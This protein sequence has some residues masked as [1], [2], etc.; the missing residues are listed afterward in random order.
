MKCQFFQSIELANCGEA[1][2]LENIIDQ[3]AFNEYGLIPVVTQDAETHQV[4]MLAYMNKDALN[5]TL[6]TKRVTYWSRSRR[7][8]WE[9]GETSGHSQNLV[10]M[11]FDCDGDAILCKVNQ[12]GSACH[13]GRSSCFYLNVDR[14]QRQMIVSGN[15][16]TIKQAK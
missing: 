1:F 7:K 2:T 8:L 10:S 4:L 15:P 12:S 14:N 13:T 3:L 11:S 6:L 5:K 9:K 16:N